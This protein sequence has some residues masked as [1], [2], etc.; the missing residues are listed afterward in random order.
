L[1]RAITLPGA[2]DDVKA[3]KGVWDLSVMTEKPDSW[4]TAV[5]QIYSLARPGV[6]HGE[7]LSNE[8]RWSVWQHPHASSRSR[9][10][11]GAQWLLHFRVLHHAY[12]MD[13]QLILPVLWLRG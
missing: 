9:S 10:F 2:S 12:R 8:P 11:S 1:G 13:G 4:S 6:R 7:V 5:Y 3:Y